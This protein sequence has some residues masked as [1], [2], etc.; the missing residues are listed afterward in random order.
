MREANAAW[1]VLGDPAARRDY[2]STLAAARRA[3]AAR[4]APRPAAPASQPQRA[5]PPPRD[6]WLVEDAGLDFHDRLGCS[7]RVLPTIVI[8]ALLLGI[9]VFTAFAATKSDDAPS[10]RLS[11]VDLLPGDCVRVGAVLETVACTSRHDAEVVTIEGMSRGCPVSTA[12]YPL[13]G[14]RVACLRPVP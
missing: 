2:D 4:A 11:I 3:A 5:A 8:F 13:D 1:A 7:I 9:F 14:T 6:P 12:V 10:T